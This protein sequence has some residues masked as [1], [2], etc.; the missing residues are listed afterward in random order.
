MDSI[1]VET[2]GEG[3][4]SGEGG[5]VARIDTERLNLEG[6]I[7]GSNDFPKEL[8]TAD[9][10]TTFAGGGEGKTVGIGQTKGSLDK[11]VTFNGILPKTGDFGEDSSGSASNNT[12]NTS[13]GGTVGGGTEV[14][15]ETGPGTDDLAAG[16]IFPNLL[17]G[18]LFNGALEDFGVVRRGGR[19]LLGLA[20]VLTAAG[21]SA[22][23][24]G[25]AIH[26]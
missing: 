10:D 4:E 11:G 16:D 17:K 12:S 5:G 20:G 26:L 25:T 21:T 23:W 1:L 7:I 15:S 9:A 13:A 22:T 6:A 24:L 18:C 2:L 8:A 3:V 14:A 19:R